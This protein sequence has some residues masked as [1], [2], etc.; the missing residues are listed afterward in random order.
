MNDCN[1]MKMIR[2]SKSLCHKYKQAITGH[3]D[4]NQAFEKLNSTADPALVEEW[5]MQEVDAQI[6]HLHDPKSMDIYI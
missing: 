5:E 1:F 6:A 4:S 3:A 2:M